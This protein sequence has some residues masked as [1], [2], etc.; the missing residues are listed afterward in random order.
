MPRAWASYA[1]RGRANLLGERS[2]QTQETVARRTATSYAAETRLTMRLLP[3]G[4]VMSCFYL[5]VVP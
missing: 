1:K 3:I 5:N 2:P 4:V